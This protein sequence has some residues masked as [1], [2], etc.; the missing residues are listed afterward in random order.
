MKVIFGL[1]NPERCYRDTRHNIGIMVIE[2]L[3]RQQSIRLRSSR[4]DAA[5]GKVAGVGE[6]VWIVR[7]SV[8]MNCSGQPLLGITRKTGVSPAEILVI[9]DDFN[10]DL[11]RMRF[12]RRGSSGGHRGLESIASCLGTE[13]FPR[14]RVGI[15]PMDMHDAVPFVLGN[16]L[17]DQWSIVKPIVIE[18]ARGAWLWAIEGIEPCMN[19]HN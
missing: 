18:A 19:R 11:G 6:P 12:R 8:N 5:V 7:S 17:E 14:L 16:F 1:G 9:C 4:F 10:I 2:E 15:G 13:D 3:A